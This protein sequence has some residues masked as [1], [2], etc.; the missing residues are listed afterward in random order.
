MPRP[1]LPA[2]ASAVT[3]DEIAA[4]AVAHIGHPYVWG[5]WDCSGMVSHVL[6]VDLGLAV[7]GYAA[8]QYQ[9]PPPHGPVVS[10]YI[11]WRGARTIAGPPA[12]GDLVCFGPDVHIGVAVSAARMVSAL[13]PALGTQETPIASTASG[14]LIYRRV[15]GTI[16]GG[17]AGRRAVR[18]SASSSQASAVVGRLLLVL[19]LAAA[20]AVVVVGA[21]ALAVGAVSSAIVAGGRSK[22]PVTKGKP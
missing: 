9:G 7:P 17:P 3:G 10:D 4:A 12:P 20:A 2:G 13:N 21:A 22:R 14:Q 16:P 11:A 5:G 8:G 15:T 6:S 19:G 18:S 1:I